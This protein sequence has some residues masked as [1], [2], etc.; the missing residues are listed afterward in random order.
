MPPMMPS[1]LCLHEFL[2]KYFSTFCA[3]LIELADIFILI[4]LFW[5]VL[6]LLHQHEWR[7]IIKTE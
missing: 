6:S 7:Q 4:E 1:V 3:K 5:T 2:D